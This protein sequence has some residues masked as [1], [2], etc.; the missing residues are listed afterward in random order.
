MT[1]PEIERVARAIDFAVTGSKD[2]NPDNLSYKMARAAIA[3]MPKTADTERLD[4]L[5]ALA[6][7]GTPGGTP[8]RTPTGRSRHIGSRARRRG[9]RRRWRSR[10]HLSALRR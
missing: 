1:R 8:R 10:Q 2:F 5:N 3:A 4:F 7:R 9:T 6:S